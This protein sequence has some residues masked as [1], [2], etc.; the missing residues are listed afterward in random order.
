MKT[1]EVLSADHKIVMSSAFEKKARRFG[2]PEYKM[3]QEARRDNPGYVEEIHQFK[4]NTKQDRYK[5]LTYDYMRWYISIVESKEDALA[6]LAG[7]EYLINISKG[8]SMCKRYSTVKSWFLKRYPDVEIFGKNEDKKA[9]EEHVAQLIEKRRRPKAQEPQNSDSDSEKN[10][11]VPAA[12][13]QSDNVTDLPVDAA[14][15]ETADAAEERK[16][17]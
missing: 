17:S 15:V 3:L 11:S 6:V 13:E 12:D 8:H 14:D 2:S 1:I 5:G 4:T 7:L 16:A 9:L 10:S